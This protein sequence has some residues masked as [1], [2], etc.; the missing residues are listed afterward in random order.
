MNRLMPDSSAQLRD[1]F[2]AWICKAARRETI[3][4]SM[5]DLMASVLTRIYH[6]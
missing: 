1:T 6:E 5:V 2:S 3:I 4:S